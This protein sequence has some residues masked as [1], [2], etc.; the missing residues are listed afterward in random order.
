MA[1][2]ACS[3][4]PA[5]LPVAS[6]QLSVSRRAAVALA[7]GAVGIAGAWL[8]GASLAFP[9]RVASASM[10]PYAARG[11]F[12]VAVHARDVRRG[13][14]VVFH[15]PFGTHGL[16]IKRA[17][18]LA[19]ECMP[20]PGA[21]PDSAALNPAV[22]AGAACVAVPEGAV[23]VLGD[24]IQASIDSRSFGS[25]P[26]GEIVGKVVLMLPV[27]GSLAEPATWFQGRLSST[28]GN[29]R[30]ATTSLWLRRIRLW[31]PRHRPSRRR[32]HWLGGWGPNFVPSALLA[33]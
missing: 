22:P 25:V 9:V 32:R 31:L 13:D 19:G 14:V 33:W 17:A 6:R 24:N 15:Y 5:P 26:A 21:G 10:E 28:E 29:P 1:L 16:A 7:A 4:S 11:D 27:G 3:Q 8:V 30:T 2:A 23:F 12:G 18:I 20:P